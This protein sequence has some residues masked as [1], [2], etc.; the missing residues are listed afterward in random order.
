MKQYYLIYTCV[1]KWVSANAAGVSMNCRDFGFNPKH[2]DDL[3]WQVRDLRTFDLIFVTN[4]YYLLILVS[5]YVLDYF[6]KEVICLSVIYVNRKD[7][8]LERINGKLTL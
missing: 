6:G 2:M 5:T 7:L 3:T 1:C 4:Y 8:K